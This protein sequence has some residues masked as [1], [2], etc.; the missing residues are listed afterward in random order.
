[1]LYKIVRDSSIFLWGANNLLHPLISNTVLWMNTSK[2]VALA[3]TVF[4]SYLGMRLWVFVNRSQEKDAPM[5]L[6]YQP[7]MNT[8]GVP[9]KSL[10]THQRTD[11]FVKYV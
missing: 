5:K 3:G 9:M 1:M 2:I 6:S 11:A 8:L 10:L 4:V 7:N